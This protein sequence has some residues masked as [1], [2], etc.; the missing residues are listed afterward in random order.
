MQWSPDRNAGFSTAVPQALY[1]PTIQDPTHGFQAVNVET[2]AADPSSLLNWMR[3]MIAVRGEHTVFGRGEMRLLYPTNRKVLAYVRETVGD[4]GEVDA[5]LCVAN[6]SRQAQ[7]VELD[8]AGFSGRVPIELNGRSAFPPIGSLP[9]LVTLPAYGFFWFLMA[10]ETEAPD[11]HLPVSQP[12]PEFITL[13]TRDGRI[14]TALDG[15]EGRQLEA[16]VMPQFLALQRWFAAKD[17]GLV[18]ASLT[19]LAEMEGP[20]ALAV[21]DVTLGDGPGDRTTERYFMPLSAVWGDDA[22][23]H[24]A[25]TLSYTMAK[26][27]RGP[28]VGALVDGTGEQAM[29]SALIGAMRSAETL[30]AATGGEVVFR[31]SDALSEIEDPGEPRLI[32]GEQSNASIV[33]GDAAV[34]KIYRRLREGVQPEIEVGR[35]LTDVAR[36][37]HTPALLG[38]IELCPAEGEPTTLASAYAFVRNQGDAWSYLTDALTRDLDDA[39]LTEEPGDFAYML[40]LP[41]LLGQRTAGMHRAL[42]TETDDPAFAPEPY[43]PGHVAA[44]AAEVAAEVERVMDD[45]ARAEPGLPEDAGPLARTVLERRGEL[46]ARL[47]ALRDAEP[48][49]M[50]TRIH[51][52]YHLGQVL[53][54]QND[55]AIIDFEGEPRRTIEERRAKFSAM[56]DVAGMLRS[57]DYAAAAALRER[58]GAALDEG[59]AEARADAWRRRA[60]AQFMDAYAEEIAGSPAHPE[61]DFAAALLELFLIQKAAYEVGYEMG[62]RPDWV[63]IPLAGL[64]SILD[65]PDMPPE[66]DGPG[67]SGPSPGAPPDMPAGTSE[68]A[69]R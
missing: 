19:P 61:P 59:R 11:W 63:A 8:L 15:R 22:L 31:G 25:P 57:L 12:L 67:A 60:R 32:P 30:P 54:A 7:A 35:F 66:E 64:V 49:G 6:L 45:L 2:Q 38:T 14:R 37:E 36:F 28:R 68:E 3:R 58:T 1:L 65:G 48:S 10:P 4:D 55:V 33:F 29:A 50:R 62:M 5:V 16:D 51:G 52:D 24:G 56:R 23:A 39:A 42:A 21:L 53:V 27:R 43:A 47:D 44:L 20:H 18:G 26:L 13:T 40:D 34:M 41:V 17:R 69:P 9:Y 46:S